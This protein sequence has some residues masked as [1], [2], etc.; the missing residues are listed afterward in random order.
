MRRLF[1]VMI[2]LWYAVLSMGF[3]VHVHYCCGDISG[4]A[5][6][7]PV[8]TK[9]CCG[10]H[11]DGCSVEKTCC[12]SE[13]FYLA[14]EEEYNSPSELVIQPSPAVE[15]FQLLPLNEEQVGQPM[16]ANQSVQINGPPRYLLFESRL[17]YG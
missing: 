12:S 14:L 17:I 16:Q 6:N 13:D 3:Q 5:I 4:I 11:H 10:A 15:S 8:E 1:A 7:Q 9:D 2:M